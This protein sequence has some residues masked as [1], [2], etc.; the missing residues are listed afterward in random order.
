[1]KVDDAM[2]VVREVRCRF[3]RDVPQ[4]MSTEDS[5]N[6]I[7]RH[8]ISVSRFGAGEFD[9]ACGL[10]AGFQ[11]ES[12]GLSGRMND[13]LRNADENAHHKIAIPLVMATLRGYTHVS[14]WW[15][16]KYCAKK[17]SAIQEKLNM[18]YVYLDS[19][20]SRI[21]IN[22]RRKEDSI[23][24]FDLWK[25][26]W[27]GERILVVEGD[28]TRFGVGNDL[29]DGASMVNRIIGPSRDAYARYE[30]I[31]DSIIDHAKDY[32]LV[33][34]ALGP[35]ATVL[36]K[37]LSDAGI[38][39]I[40]S[41]NLDLEYEWSMRKTRKKVPIAGKDSPEVGRGMPVASKQEK[42]YDEQIIDKVL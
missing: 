6:Y 24:Y 31:Y 5:L 33:L 11:C 20:I 18:D 2:L 36:A 35:T 13:M 30:E 26:L 22:R 39:A 10:R 38:W 41:G 1:M 40:D 37:D 42:A 9:I 7:A 32:D 29:M 4:V 17:R 15:W 8:R 16:L 27:Q 19:Q 23:R 21:Y 25:A 34:L 3:A 14:Q 12:R 28:N